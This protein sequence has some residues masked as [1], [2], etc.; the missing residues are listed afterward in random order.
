MDDTH[1]RIAETKTPREIINLFNET[2][3]QSGEVPGLNIGEKAP[4]FSL[5]NQYNQ[6][7]TLKDNLQNGPVILSFYRGEWCRH[8]F[9]TGNS[10]H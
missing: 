4:N 9:H 7:V 5:Q 2:L 6:N 8:S 3:T 1:N 10:R